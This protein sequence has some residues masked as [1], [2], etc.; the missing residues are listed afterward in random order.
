MFINAKFCSKKTCSVL[1][2]KQTHK[3]RYTMPG[4]FVIRIH[5]HSI[6]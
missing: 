5:I 2:D 4:V 3:L 1:I 6:I